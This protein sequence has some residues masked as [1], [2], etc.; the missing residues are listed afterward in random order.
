MKKVRMILDLV[1]SDEF[2]NA[3]IDHV[4]KE[5]LSGKLQREFRSGYKNKPGVVHSVKVLM[6]INNDKE[7]G[8]AKFLKKDLIDLVQQLKDYTHESHNILGHDERSAE[9]FVD[10]FLNPK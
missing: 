8:E 7:L 4:R 6:E 10:L 3:E 2:Y 9:E 1:V 5:I